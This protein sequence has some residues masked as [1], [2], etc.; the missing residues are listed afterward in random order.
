MTDGPS[1]VLSVFQVT[2]I[3]PLGCEETDGVP[4]SCLNCDRWL[5]P[6][7]WAPDMEGV[8]VDKAA[9]TVDRQYMFA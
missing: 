6:S 5:Y 1:M 8:T 4:V 7:S 3:N 2:C 9:E